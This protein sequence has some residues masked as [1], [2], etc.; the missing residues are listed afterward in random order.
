MLQVC[1]Y[2]NTN[3]TGFDI[4][5]VAL[6]NFHNHKNVI[7][8]LYTFRLY[9]VVRVHI[10]FYYCP[11]KKKKKM[12]CIVATLEN[13]IHNISYVP[14]LWIKKN[15]LFWPPDGTTQ[16]KINKMRE[17]NTQPSEDWIK[18]KCNVRETNIPTYTEGISKEKIYAEFTDT[19]SE[20]L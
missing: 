13:G 15:K 7:Q 9:R 3:A 2:D 19:E 18:L 14:T 5:P 11:Y 20:L 17:K 16:K 12:Y 4:S 6:N 1:K 10:V 8:Y